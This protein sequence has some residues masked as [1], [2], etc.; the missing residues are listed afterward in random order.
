MTIFLLQRDA[1]TPLHT[2]VHCF[3][4]PPPPAD[5]DAIE[6]ARWRLLQQVRPMLNGEHHLEE[7]A[8][9]E[10]IERAALADMLRAY[11]TDYLT[12][13]MTPHALA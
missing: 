2:Q 9:Q 10:G 13:F 11:E 5:A 8:W 3:A 6:V 4:E 12:C 1:L 7:I